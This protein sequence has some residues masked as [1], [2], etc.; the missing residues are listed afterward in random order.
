MK[1]LLMHRDRDFLRP[2]EMPREARY[3]DYGE[4]QLS[5]QQRAFIQDLEVNVVL[6]AMAGDDSF[7]RE[8]A[9]QAILRAAANDIDTIRYRQAALR[10]CLKNAAV[11]RQLYDLTVETIEARKKHWW[12]ISSRFVGSILHSAVDL[13][14]MFV[15]M[16]HQL[17]AVTNANGGYFESEAFTSLFATLDREL[18]DEYLR[19]VENHLS[20]LRFRGG[21]LVSGE[22]GQGNAVTGYVLR[23]PRERGSKWLKRIFRRGP[24]A[25]TFHLHAR[26]EAGGRILSEM[27]D[28]GINSVANALAQSADH[29]LCFFE[30]LRA[31]LAFY[32]GCLNLHDRLSAFGA[33]TCLP[34]PAPLGA[35]SHCF[36]ELYDVSLALTMGRR[37]VGNTVDANG[38]SLIII[39]GANQGGK[40]SFLRSVGLAQLMMQ[41]GMFVGA[42]SLTADLCCGVFTHYKREEDAT[43]K[44][45][46]FDEEV[47][48]MNDI[49]NAIGPNALMLFN[50]SFAA[51][52]EREGS[53]IARQV[54]SALLESGIKV[55]FVT[56]L[57]DFAHGVFD[58]KLN[59]AIFLRAER[60][61]D[62]TRTFRLIEGEP[63]ATSY[64]E[65]LY[66]EIF[67][68]A[69]QGS[70]RDFPRPEA[71]SADPVL[72]PGTSK[73]H[74]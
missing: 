6:A 28:R 41:C 42:E 12:G 1:S 62:G 65:D 17:R 35:R 72:V 15:G 67:A 36:S 66:S 8:I 19:G 56:H 52:N 53:E 64:G 51:T 2:D 60:R 11:I 24:P 74:E 14:Q 48:R 45:G 68:G 44:K 50:E 26:D 58:K 38:K 59:P 57:Y 31:E 47:S 23:Q 7:L 70:H 18:S 49:A 13:M 4:P 33:P 69:S 22:L 5:P 20:E 55:F 3:R 63:Q 32:V 37:I 29:V 10:D 30:T 73:A 54:V 25:Y 40:S 21:V 46:K 9:R 27:R 34:E 16:L 71:P 39:T 43:M 61:V